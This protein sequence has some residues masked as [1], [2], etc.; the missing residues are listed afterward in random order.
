M[1]SLEMWDSF[2]SL[3]HDVTSN[4]FNVIHNCYEFCTAIDCCY[5][6][7]DVK[8]INSRLAAFLAVG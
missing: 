2:H 7:Y 4:S 3:Q 5:F 8:Q 6:N 1:K